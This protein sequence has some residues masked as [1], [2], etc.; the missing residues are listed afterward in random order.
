MPRG[1]R[2]DLPGFPLHVIQRGNNRSACFFSNDDCSAYLY[3]LRQAAEKL[4]CLVHAYVLMTNHVHLLVTPGRTGAISELMQSLGR[5]YVRYV[6]HAYRRSGTLWE[7]RFK[8]SPVHAEAYLL[9]C[10][11]YIELN[12]VRAGMVEQPGD[13]RWSSFRCNGLGQSDPLVTEHA[14]YT[15]LACTPNE[16]RETYRATFRAQMDEEA[17][18]EIRSA[19]QA[20]T[21]LSGERFRRELERAHQIRLSARPRGRPPKSAEDRVRK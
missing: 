1:L 19:A 5:R 15:A 3:W 8:A 21:L 4:D 11:R 17:L 16:R 18:T 6:N 9:K 14:V 7:G 2:F 12:P 13:F 10:M 20:G